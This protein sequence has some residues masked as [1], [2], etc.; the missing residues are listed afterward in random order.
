M[1]I[2]QRLKVKPLADG[3]ENKL[4]V[5]RTNV[6]INQRKTRFDLRD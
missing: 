2:E 6:T 1:S 3:D 5:K 4:L